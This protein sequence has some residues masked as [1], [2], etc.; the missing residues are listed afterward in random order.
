MAERINITLPEDLFK[1]LQEVKG[2]FKVSRVCQ[3]AIRLAITREK[4]KAKE[5]E[6]MQE[7]IERLRVQ[8][9]EYEKKYEEI[10]QED[11]SNDGSNFEYAD[12]V[13]IVKDGCQHVR[14]EYILD[15]A[16]REYEEDDPAFDRAMYTEGW[17]KGIREFWDNL[18]VELNR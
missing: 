15:D 2:R 14:D 6:T 5:N 3:E 16:F 13:E 17:V 4:F 18:Q 11:G 10:G 7:T 12:L 1:E 9:E 8:K